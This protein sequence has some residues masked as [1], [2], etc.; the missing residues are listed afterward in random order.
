MKTRE[1]IK[2]MMTIPAELYDK[3]EFF[4]QDVI[5]HPEVEKEFILEKVNDFLE[6][7][8][9]TRLNKAAILSALS[10]WECHSGEKEYTRNTPFGYWRWYAARLFSGKVDKCIITVENYDMYDGGEEMYFDFDFEIEM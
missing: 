6:Q 5:T 3:V 7:E 1:D 2:E 8:G 9:N 10:W 4:L